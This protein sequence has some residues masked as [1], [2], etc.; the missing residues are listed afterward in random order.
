MDAYL[1]IRRVKVSPSVVVAHKLALRKGPAV[2]PIRRVK[3]KSYIIPGGNPSMRKDNMFSGLIPKTLVF[4]LVDSDA[5]NCLYTKNPFNFKNFGVSSVVNG[6][7]I[8]F[9]PISLHYAA[10]TP[11]YIEAYGTLFSGTGKMYHNTGNDISRFEYPNGYTL[12]AFDLT[13][14]MC[15]SS[16]HFNVVQKGNLSIEIQFDAANAG[17]VSMVCYREFENTV[18]IDS[19]RNMLYDY[20]G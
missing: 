3:C 12:Y 14:D 18:H 16:S 15:G 2:Y 7:D 10:A 6:E 11:R 5:Y 13:P 20:S 1:K 9:R 17:A 4:G 19:E 8:P